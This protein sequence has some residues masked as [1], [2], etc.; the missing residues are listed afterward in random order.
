MTHF[1]LQLNEIYLGCPVHTQ[2]GF[3]FSQEK[4]IQWEEEIN[5]M[6]TVME[7]LLGPF[8]VNFSSS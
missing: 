8:L 2:A 7:I 1:K 6:A 3:L 5:T 4:Y